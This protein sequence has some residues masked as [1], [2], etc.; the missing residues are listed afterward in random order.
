[1]L[2]VLVMLILLNILI[3]VSLLYFNNCFSLIFYERGIINY[4]FGSVAI[5]SRVFSTIPITG[6]ITRN[7]PKYNTVDTAPQYCYH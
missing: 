4:D 5:S 1:V 2:V 3:I 6:T 7:H